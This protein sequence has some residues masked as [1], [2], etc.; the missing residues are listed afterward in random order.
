[1]NANILIPTVEVKFKGEAFDTLVKKKHRHVY[2][3]F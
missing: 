2:A 1:M 3:F